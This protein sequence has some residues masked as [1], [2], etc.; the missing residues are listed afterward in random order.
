[1]T[2]VTFLGFPDGRL[3]AD[4]ELRRAIS[5]VIRRFRPGPGGRPVA[6]AQLGAH[7][8][9]PSRPPGRRR[10]GRLCRL[11]RRPQPV[12]LPRAARRGVRAP[13]RARD[14][15]DGHRPGR[16]GGGHHRRLRPQAGRAAFPPQP[17]RRRR[18]ARGTAA[19]LDVAARRWPR[20]CPMVGW[21]RP[22]TWSAP[23]SAAALGPAG[24]STA[25]RSSSTSPTRGRD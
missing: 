6:R 11:S 22:S 24:R 12:R 5:R 14:V 17:G 3:V 8:R 7:L 18:P 4:L 20:A 9:Q 13:H 1:M 15:D 19:Q 2:D 23:G 25:G 10:G 16:P 21:P